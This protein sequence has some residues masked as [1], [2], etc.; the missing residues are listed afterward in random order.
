MKLPLC[1]C[2]IVE[3]K[4]EGV[5]LDHHIKTEQSYIVLKGLLK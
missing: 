2:S 1:N 4:K 3:E 5:L